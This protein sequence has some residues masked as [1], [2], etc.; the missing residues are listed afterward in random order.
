MKTVSRRTVLRGIGGSVIALPWL[1]AMSDRKAMA[2]EPPKRF[3]V[4]YHGAGTYR[5]KWRPTGTETDFKLSYI[6]EPLAPHQKDIVVID[7][8][9]L[10]S[11]VDGKLVGGHGQGM[12]G[13]LT[14]HYVTTGSMC[15]LGYGQGISIDQ[16]LAGKIGGNT[17]I[18]SLLLGADKESRNAGVFEAASYS[19]P[20][21][22]IPTDA[23]PFNVFKRLFSDFNTDT[24]AID[25][26][27]D[28][29]KSVLDVVGES[30][31][32]IA[33]RVSLD[34]RKKIEAHL[35]AIRGVE[36]RLDALA[37]AASGCAKPTPGAA[38]DVNKQA[39]FPQTIKL[40]MDLMVMALACDLTRVSTLQCG[41]AVFDMYYPWLGIPETWIHNLTHA[42]DNDVASWD[43]VAKIKRWH[44]E[45]FSYLLT[46]MKEIKEGDQT[47]LDNTLVLNI[48]EIGKGNEHSANNV[49][50][51]LAGHAG[52]A[53]R[54]GRF[55]S[56]DPGKKI[57]HNNLLLSILH[58]FDLPEKSFGHAPWCT[59]P[60]AGLL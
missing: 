14:G 35:T 55:L 41:D 31:T 8:L 38:F 44:E 26:L 37:T 22:T 7:G 17:K 42:G 20:G 28:Q 5:P 30:F 16:F 46:K 21:K 23:D 11:G 43:K 40:Q 6:L 51:V 9:V 48:S 13:M 60:L 25:R 32:R 1:E 39:S 15:G 24:K 12:A 58:A 3:V 49:P 10:A 4:H 47:L 45:Q 36:L 57:L 56:F 2:A 59:G 54:T 50:I 19:A 27:R 18:R 52:K 53:I 33:P 29:R 34:D